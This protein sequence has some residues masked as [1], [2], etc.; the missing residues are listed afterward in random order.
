MNI[1]KDKVKLAICEIQ[2]VQVQIK[3]CIAKWTSFK[4]K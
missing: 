1:F 3:V 4:I 2:I